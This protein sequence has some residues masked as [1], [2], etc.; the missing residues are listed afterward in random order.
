MPHAEAQTYKDPIVFEVRAVENSNENIDKAKLLF[1]YAEEYQKSVRELQERYEVPDSP[2]ITDGIKEV[3]QM[4]QILKQI[5]TKQIE[6]SDAEEIISSI[7][8]ELKNVSTG[9][10]PYLKSQQDIYEKELEEIKD[11]YVRVGNLISR[12][13]Y[14]FIE[15]FSQKLSEKDTL[16]SK[17]KELVGSLVKLNKIRESIDS[18]SRLSFRTKGGMKD[19]YISIIQSI[20]KEL[21]II[22][23]LLR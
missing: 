1:K 12:A 8:Q 20:K 4:K 14:N 7:V 17:Q 6:K 3:D 21:Q 13:L 15:R 5:Q 11:N 10:N 18:F 9:M 2:I 16:N 19:F 23:E 22:R